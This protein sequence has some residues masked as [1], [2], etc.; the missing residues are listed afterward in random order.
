MK[1]FPETKAIYLFVAPFKRLWSAS[2]IRG[3]K[4][5]SPTEPQR[6]FAGCEK[7][8]MGKRRLPKTALALLV[9]ATVLT[10]SAFASQ[11]RLQQ[12]VSAY[13]S[14]DAL[15]DQGRY[16]EAL[17]SYQSALSIF[18]SLLGP[19]HPHV[20]AALNNMSGAYKG[21]GDTENAI[22]VLKRALR[23]RQKVLGSS[24]PYTGSTLVNLA[25]MYQETGNYE[26][27][28]KFF[29]Q[30]SPIILSKVGKNHPNRALFSSNL[31]S[32]HLDLGHLE[33]AHEL[34]EDALL[35]YRRSGTPSNDINY[36]NAFNNMATV[37]H[38]Q[39]KYDAAVD[40][41]KKALDGYVD[42][43]GDDHPQALIIRSNLGEIYRDKGQYAAAA[44]MLEVALKSARKLKQ[45][46]QL[47]QA[48]IL[49]GLGNLY[50]DMSDTE[51]A[52]ER[53]EAAIEIMEREKGPKDQDVLTM[54]NNIAVILRNSGQNEQSLALHQQVLAARKEALGPYH[55]DIAQ[56][57][58]NI[59]GVYQALGRHDEAIKWLTGAHEQFCKVLGPTHPSSLQAS[60]NLAILM[61]ET[62]D[63]AGALQRFSEVYDDVKKAL[64]DGHARTIEALENLADVQYRLGETEAAKKSA[65]ALVRAKESIL[66][67]VLGM[68]ERSRLSWQAKHLSLSV[69]PFVLSPEQLATT[70]LRRKGIVLDSLLEDRMLGSNS[71]EDSSTAALLDE[72]GTLRGRIAELTLGEGAVDESKRLALLGRVSEI[73]R[74]LASGNEK[75][76][77]SRRG[78][79]LTLDGLRACLPSDAALVDFVSF[80]D[81]KND[82]PDNLCYGAIII[83]S[84]AAHE[85]SQSGE[86]VSFV[87][88]DNA[89]AI[90]KAVSSL[91]ASLVSG[92]DALLE[93]SIADLSEKLWSGI[94]EK[95]PSNARRLI[96]AA[97]GQL[98]FVPFVA[99]QKPDGSFL[100]EHYGIVYVGSA[101]DLMRPSG[102]QPVKSLEIFADPS[103]TSG[104]SGDSG[105]KRGE[106]E[107]ESSVFSGVNLPQLPGTVKENESLRE[108]AETNQWRANSYL[109]ESATEKK[110]R[111]IDAP[112]ILHLATHGFYL[113]SDSLQNDGMR[114]MQVV[115]VGASQGNTEEKAALNPMLASGFALSGAQDTF[116]SWTRKKPLPSDNDGVVTAEEAATL[117]LKGT[118][119]VTL[120][121][122]ETG[123]GEARS[124]E[125][126]F[127]LRRAFMM[128]GAENLI[129]TLWPVSDETTAEIMSE[130]YRQAL[131]TG[132]AAG[133]L[134]TVQREWL[135]KLK[136]SKGFAGAVREAAPFA[137][138]M[139]AN[140]SAKVS[141]SAETA[142]PS[143]S[144]KSAPLS[145]LDILRKAQVQAE[146]GDPYSLAVLSVCYGLGYGV[147]QDLEKSKQ[148]AMRSAKA[149]HPMGIYRLAEMR[150]KGETMEANKEQAERLRAKARSGLTAL[151]K[152]P[153]ALYLLAASE[154]LTASSSKRSLEL[155]RKAADLG[156]APAQWIYAALLE[157]AGD[158]PSPEQI[159]LAGKYRRLCK[160]QGF[161]PPSN[162]TTPT[163]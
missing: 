134:A 159:E 8:W 100:G 124:G 144:D 104:T 146:L 17:R 105:A 88:I 93:D 127:G 84:K 137:I 101:R 158:G 120:S 66:P 162:P 125:G 1:F 148:Y 160:E 64:G 20:A 12:G 153:F 7:L 76:F 42:S 23:I 157:E 55:A 68:D 15:S 29:E 78:I 156:F 16:A 67:F 113:N 115:G 86:H 79:N 126:V 61:Y 27:A 91:R 116:Q 110:L 10:T 2:S 112:G 142:S 130:F 74:K 6:D 9:V 14:G 71:R 99:L 143:T 35:I 52:V 131:A 58:G 72:M 97:D 36:L 62:G 121:A 28:L 54:K 123:V 30:A 49:N 118:W 129:M 45:G 56:S 151:K 77:T 32:L 117:D 85:S 149:E 161:S 145:C 18:E 141:P 75:S 114:G 154:L 108:I 98:S 22:K 152:D 63:D 94:Q 34:L 57:M 132:D 41:Y 109:G 122:C 69:E 102:A 53:Y 33:K 43:F 73:E 40:A 37:Y 133:S 25:T 103:F 48:M 39:G 31:A 38:K 128:A 26:A 107:P 147:T 136:Q 65:E 89:A 81:V 140:P 92:N 70:T 150:E 90:D 5:S 21:L 46:G 82:G 3:G 80:D 11:A 44:D 50:S 51:R 155:Y 119:L 59:A 4:R 24:H 60:G 106:S 95:L 87:K 83:S 19:E 163:P 96:I 135:L 139:M 47:A 138:A 13:E 111:S